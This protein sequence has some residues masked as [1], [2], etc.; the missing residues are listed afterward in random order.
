MASTT[1]DPIMN[2]L[3][4]YLQANIPANTFYTFARGFVMWEQVSQLINGLP[5]MRQPAL[6][7]YDGMGAGGGKI[8][9]DRKSRS[10]P[11]IRI[12]DRTIVIYAQSPAIGSQPGGQGGGPVDL[13]QSGGGGPILHPLIEVVE[14]ALS[15]PDKEGALT[16]GGLVSHCWL[17]GDAHLLTPDISPDGQGMATLPVRIMVP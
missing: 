4:A 10:L 15:I 8:T 5:I 17:Q 11:P 16:L 12:M 13:T 2:A 7:L 14:A 9:Y 6:W 1:Y 3:L